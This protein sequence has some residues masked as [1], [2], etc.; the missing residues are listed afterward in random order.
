MDTQN[1][2]TNTHSLPSSGLPAIYEAGYKR[3]RAA[4]AA[5]AERYVRQTTVGDAAA[6]AVMDELAPRTTGEVN[7]LIFG[8]M[9]QDEGQR[10]AAPRVVRDFFQQV[11]QSPAW[12]DPKALVSGCRA[13][14]SNPTVFMQAFVVAT[15]RNASTPIAKSF[16]ASGR[17]MGGFGL[18]RIR[19]NTRHF[20]EIMLPHALERQ[21]DGWKLSVRIRLVHARLRR[22]IR[23]ES[24]WDEQVYGVPLSAAHL[25]LAASNFSATTARFANMLGAKLGTEERDAFMQV[26]RHSSWLMGVPENLL[27][28]GDYDATAEFSEVGHSCEPPPDDESRA[29]AK[30]V[31]EALPLIAGKDPNVHDA[32]ITHAWRV[33]RA[34]LGK[35]LA[36][37]LEIPQFQTFG[38]LTRTRAL[39]GALERIGRLSPALGKK[40]YGAAGG[41]FAF[42]LEAS[43][44]QELGY[45]LPDHLDTDRSIP[46]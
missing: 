6:D 15:L 43:M 20:I 18:R 42:L 29:V 24:D 26:W 36:D 37:G 11:E 33:A 40:L 5:L 10:R 8:M 31:V 9:H 30:A 2:K 7:R 19:Q 1:R 21:A 35:E 27:F 22:L 38:V 4:N 46:W 3:A 14:H 13:F 44:L 23:D 45:R 32:F 28:G 41:A 34:L 17:V 25:A 16:H 12:F 39:N